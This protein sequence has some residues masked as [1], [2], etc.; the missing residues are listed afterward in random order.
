PV[1]ASLT[2]SNREGQ[3]QNIAN[4]PFGDHVAI[5]YWEPFVCQRDLLFDMVGK[6]R[7]ENLDGEVGV[8]KGIDLDVKNADLTSDQTQ[9]VDEDVELPGGAGIAAALDQNPA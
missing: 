7:I 3:V 5:R 9:R 1:E 4:R 2:C 6:T 8:S